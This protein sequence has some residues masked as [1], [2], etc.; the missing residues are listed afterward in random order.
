M[1]QA[2]KIRICSDLKAFISE[3]LVLLD[4]QKPCRDEDANEAEDSRVPLA[5]EILQEIAA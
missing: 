4:E 1:S 2:T 3:E 5:R